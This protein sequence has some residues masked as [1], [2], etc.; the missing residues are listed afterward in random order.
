[1]VSY[2]E[3]NSFNILG[4]ELVLDKV[5]SYRSSKNDYKFNYGTQCKMVNSLAI[6]SPYIS[7]PDGS[8]QKTNFFKSLEELKYVIRKVII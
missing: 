5:V 1:M 3:G 7:S 4:G 8:A 2:C 6:R